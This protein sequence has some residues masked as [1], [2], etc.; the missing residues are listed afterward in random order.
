MPVF[1]NQLILVD[2]TIISVVSCP[3][4]LMVC[5][6]FLSAPK[7]GRVR[8]STFRKRTPRRRSRLGKRKGLMNLQYGSVLRRLAIDGTD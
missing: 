1:D 6:F 7:H 2:I 3:T 4:F 5:I 8:V